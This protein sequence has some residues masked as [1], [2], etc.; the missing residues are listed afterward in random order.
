MSRCHIAQSS[1]PTSK[2]G[3]SAYLGTNMTPKS[4]IEAT[5]KG[6]DTVL[7]RDNQNESRGLGIATKLGPNELV[8]FGGTVDGKYDPG[9]HYVSG[10]DGKGALHRLVR[11]L[12]QQRLGSGHLNRP[13]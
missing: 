12:D 10:F 9:G 11:G 3:G 1:I 6:A 2:H 7:R 5:D 8:D 4:T 13:D